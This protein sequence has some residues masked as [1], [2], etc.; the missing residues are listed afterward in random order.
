MAT[1]RFQ[2]PKIVLA[3]ALPV[4]LL[5]GCGG[6]QATPVPVS[7]TA[8]TANAG[9]PYT[10]TE[11][12]AVSFNGSG[13]TDPQGQTLSYAWSFGDGTTG[14]GARPSHTYNIAGTFTVTLTVTDTSN[15]SG[16]ATATAAISV[17]MGTYS[18][19]A[20]SG[21]VLAGSTPV[22]GASVQLWAAGT[23]GNGS[24]PT[25]LLQN[26]LTTDSNGAFTVSAGYS[27]P[28]ATS[29]LFLTSSGGKAG[30]AG[31]S[32]TSTELMTVPGACNSIA[33]NASYVV[34]EVTTVASAYALGQFLK[35]GAQLGATA[36]NSSGITLAAATLASLVNLTTGV[37]PGTAFP[38]TGTAPTAKINSL[39]NALHACIVS[40]GSSSAACSGL[41]GAVVP[42]GTPPTNTLD[43]MLALATKPGT[44][45]TPIYAL[46]LASAAFTPALTAAPSD[47]VV[48]ATFGGGGMNAP[49]A[50]ALDSQGRVW[51]ASYFSVASL[52]SNTGV[53]VLPSGVTGNG[54]YESYGGAV[55]A[56]DNFWQ[57]DEEGGG[58]NNGDG[59]VTVFN[60]Q[61]SNVTG[62]PYESGGIYFPYA[63]AVDT[64]N[65]SWVVDYG[66]SHVTLLS[67][68]GAPLSG[69]SGYSGDINGTPTLFFPVAIAI[70][71]N[72]NG[73]L[74][75]FS[76]NT[77]AK[78][79]ADGTKATAYV[80]CDAPDGLAIDGQGN[81]WVANYYGDSVS[82]L[83]A[84][85]TV[86]SAGFKGGGIVHPQGIAVDG[87][88]NV[89]VA[90]Y[91]GPSISELAGA[92]GSS[93][94]G[95]VLSPTAGWA[96]DANVLEAF[97]L[98]IDASGNIWVTSFGSN[99][100]TEYVGLAAPVKT[101]L[102][103]P[104]RVP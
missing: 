59:E 11:G 68:A 16:Q 104:V 93:T 75:N 43:A 45:V 15:L 53:P 20:L 25:Q 26:A 71:A 38:A 80:C 102:L 79:S 85:G 77:V 57:V 6:N 52:F 41:Y 19:N 29:I 23:A 3:L 4:L 47:W 78:I 34:D 7:P 12:T 32:N 51:V 14:T 74:A 27:C 10:G 72:R 66:D 69:A 98:A 1:T 96:P 2:A 100:I 40:T 62:S 9:G 5:S 95:T 83:T 46:T 94:A 76:S 13:S 54:L 99:T 73:W 33:T 31:A 37:A 18:G 87:V 55:D 64:A 90:N 24:T 42:S 48:Y 17:V 81:V 21:K 61:G 35:P 88:G 39:A 22:I 67:N 82:L 103:G 97:A 58:S 101:P 44:N 28:L 86:V 91:R 8:P 63:I 84:A 60:T 30:A 92:S 50:L 49:S 56:N 36:T 70:D 89:W 65:V